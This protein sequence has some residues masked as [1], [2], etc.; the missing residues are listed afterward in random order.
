MADGAEWLA[1]L[2]HIFT[3]ARARDDGERCAVAPSPELK[4]RIEAELAG[5]RANAASVLSPLIHVAE[6][7]RPGLNDGLIIPPSKFPLGT[8]LSLIRSAAADRA[9]LAGVVRVIVVLVDFSDKPMTQTAAHFQQ[10]FFSPGVIPTKS[11]REY[12]QDVTHGIIDIQGEV[13]GPYRL[14][15]TLA[16]YAH[17]ASGLGGT[18]PNATTMARD[19][20]LAADPAVNFAPYD[21]DGNGFVDAFIVIHAGR[22]AEETGSSGDIWSHKWTLDGGARTVDTTKVYGYLTVPEDA[23]IGVCCHELGHL[24]FGFPDLYDTDN[25][26]EGIGNWCL[27]AA[28][29]WGGGGDTPVHPSA[30]CK[31]NQ[32]WAAVD[33]RMGNGPLTIPDVKTSHTVYRLWKDGAPGGEY[34]LLENREPTGFDASLPGGGLLIWHIDESIGGNTNELH[35]KVALVQGDNLKNLEHNTNRGDAGDPYPG[36][37]NNTSFTDTA[38]PNSKSYAGIKTC[39]S[40]TGISPAGPV[41][42]ANV[43]VRCKVIEKRPKEHAKE[44]LKD[45]ELNQDKSVVK[46]KGID[47]QQIVDKKLDK[48]ISEKK[49]EKP[50][51]DKSQGLDKAFDKPGDG[52]KLVDGK[53]GLPGGLGGGGQHRSS[54]DTAI[55][56]LNMRMANVEAMLSQLVGGGQGGQGGGG[57]SGEGGQS[58]AEGS[59][60]SSGGAGPQMSGG[61]AQ[62]FIGGDLRPDLSQGALMQEDDS[63]AAQAEMQRGSAGAKRQYDK[64][65][66]H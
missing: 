43:T 11:V 44:V 26:S 16:T 15:Q 51:T 47:K 13:V 38:T 14:P 36:T 49:A 54:A 32:G 52:G 24:L 2:G 39:V 5:I 7:Q 55:A 61:A 17:G 22:G 65:A 56:S 48:P 62:P 45:K 31:A 3:E 40:V 46:D 20:L 12:Y 60:E 30:W 34:F 64:S 10:L 6:P 23:K 27:M 57:Q 66:E 35:Y 25:S 28:G 50:V 63:P 41:M 8:P 19:A 4:Q 58:G 1:G 21:N 29:S 53:P 37:S 59:G 33:N 42:T 18:L 9:P